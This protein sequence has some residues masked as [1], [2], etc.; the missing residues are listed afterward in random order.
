VAPK[1]IGSPPPGLYTV[2]VV[3]HDVPGEGGVLTQGAAFVATGG[4]AACTETA[5]PANLRA[6]S[7]GSASIGLAWDPVPGAVGYTLLRNE[8][9]CGEPMPADRSLSLPANATSA[10]DRE[11]VAD[12]V[13]HYTV[14]AVTS[15]AGCETEDSACVSV[16]AAD[17]APPPAVPDGRNGNGLVVGKGPTAFR[18]VVD[19]DA[20]TCPA[21]GYHLL[22]GPLGGVGDYE[23][24]GARCGLGGLGEYPWLG[25]PADDLWFVVVSSSAQRIEGSWGE[26][27]DGAPR[28][29]GA[30]SGQCGTLVRDESAACE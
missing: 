28:G 5:P 3:A 19:W 8:T 16:L 17:A 23:I 2:R 20:A 25:V 29:G 27:S 18:L 14:R 22:F 13:Y 30:A 24:A 15:A 7:F 1:W 26:S 9:G 11:V 4:I 21:E 12:A 10:L 6:E